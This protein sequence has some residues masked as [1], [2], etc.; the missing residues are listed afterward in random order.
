MFVE[1]VMT[2][3]VVTVT[4]ETTTSDA[5]EL[6]QEG[7]FRHLPVVRLGRLVGIVSDR[8]LRVARMLA[9]DPPVGRLGSADV[10]MVEPGTPVE[11]AS[12][13]MVE[14]KIG[15]LPVVRDGALVGIVTESDLFRMLTRVMGVL[16]PSSRLQLDLDEPTDNWRT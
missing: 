2:T 7:H 8:D 5:W 9:E 3:P 11:E 1:Q 10:L 6:L 13:L 12:R 4:P 16:E 14:Q 15:A